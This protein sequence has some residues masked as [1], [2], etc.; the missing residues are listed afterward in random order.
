MR[1]IDVVFFDIAMS[2]VSDKYDSVKEHTQE[3]GELMKLR[4]QRVW[5]NAYKF[6]RQLAH[7]GLSMSTVKIRI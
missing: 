3:I 2:S 1:L 7:G 6:I 4:I 5:Q